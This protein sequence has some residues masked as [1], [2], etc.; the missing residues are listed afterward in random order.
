MRKIAAEIDLNRQHEKRN[1]EL[2]Q[3]LSHLEEENGRLLRRCE[4]AE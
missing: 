1:R 3:E 2:L 4:L